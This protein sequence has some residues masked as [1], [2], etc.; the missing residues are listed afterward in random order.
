[1]LTRWFTR[2]QRKFLSRWPDALRCGSD[3]AAT[4]SGHRYVI[5]APARGG[6]ADTVFWSAEPLEPEQ[7]ER[8]R[9]AW[10]RTCRLALARRSVRMLLRTLSQQRRLY[11][12]SLHRGPCQYLT[13]AQ[14]QAS[15]VAALP[16][17]DSRA[18]AETELFKLVTD[19]VLQLRTLYRGHYHTYPEGLPDLNRQLKL[20]ANCWPRKDS[21]RRL[22]F[23]A[24][25][26]CLISSDEVEALAGNNWFKLVCRPPSPARV[27]ALRPL[28]VCAE[29]L[30]LKIRCRGQ[31]S[32]VT[33]YWK[34]TEQ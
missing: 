30:D 11:A 24:M 21:T 14:L 34:P 4:S 25:M 12:T 7:F 16:P 22:A 26:I 29:A 2:L 10:R 28:A 13:A 23:E 32:D 8:L 9:D 17:G 15:V 33:V 3:M 27:A 18:E 6:G 19:S 1:M 20:E 31:A 5:P